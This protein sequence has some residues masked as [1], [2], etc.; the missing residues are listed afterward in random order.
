MC[1]KIGLI[2]IV[3][4]IMIVLGCCFFVLFGGSENVVAAPESYESQHAPGR[5]LF[6]PLMYNFR[7]QIAE[8]PRV[9]P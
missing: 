8:D 5:M 2:L 9:S 4:C 6:L 3:L 1:K 7:H